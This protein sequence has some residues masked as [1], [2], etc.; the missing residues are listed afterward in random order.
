MKPPEVLSTQSVIL[1]R[2]RPDMADALDA[3]IVESLP[4]L[5]EF[6]PWATDSH[7]LK[8][9]KE[10]IDRSVAEWDKEE[11]FNYALVAPDGAVIGSSGLMTRMGP[12]ILEIGYWVHSAYAGK[13]IAT[14]VAIALAGAGS[15]LD[16]IERL[17]I[18]HDVANPAS[19]RVA[20]K[21]GFVA[22]A[23][24]DRDPESS[25]DSGVDRIWELKV[26]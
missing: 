13:G 7:G 14:A 22:T 6:M 12:G 17:V 11:S 26:D 16:G 20:E 25:G 19:G 10:Y 4:E 9:T 3:A 18:K 2:W 1:R 23:E 5:K 24:V 15:R 21:A 8:E